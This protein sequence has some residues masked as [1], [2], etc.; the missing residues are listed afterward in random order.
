MKTHTESKFLE[1]AN[2][3]LTEDRRAAQTDIANAV[4]LLVR[5]DQLIKRDAPFPPL[6]LKLTRQCIGYYTKVKK[7]LIG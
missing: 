2:K 6:V 3:Q 7:F 4:Q 1:Q 5:T